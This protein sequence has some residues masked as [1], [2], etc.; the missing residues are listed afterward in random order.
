MRRTR[1]TSAR[2]RASSTTRSR[3]TR[4]RAALSG[5]PLAPPTFPRP[6]P[7]KFPPLL[8]TFQRGS[9]I[10]LCTSQRSGDGSTA[11]GSPPRN[12]RPDGAEGARGR[13]SSA[14]LWHR[15]A[16]RAG[17]RRPAAVERRHGLYRVDA[18]E[19]E[20]LDRGRVGGV[21]K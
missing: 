7:S 2:N 4:S 13:R 10:L 9:A 17:E 11:I 18:A 3:S 19:A 6:P 15:A 12:A 8:W 20:R 16:A 14:R 21:G 1:R 5:P